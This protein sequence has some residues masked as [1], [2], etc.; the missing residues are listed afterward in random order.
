MS[1]TNKTDNYH[2]SQFVGTD[3]PSILNDYNGDMRKIDTAIKEVATA[4]GDNATNIAELQVSVRQHGTEIGGLNS[5]V[6][7]LSG[8]VIEIESKIPLDASTENQLVT[9]EQVLPKINKLETSVEDILDS[10]VVLRFDL[11]VSEQN[12][13]YGQVLNDIKNAVAQYR[14]SH[15]EY[16]DYYVDKFVINNSTP[17][18]ATTPYSLTFSDFDLISFSGYRVGESFSGIY[19]FEFSADKVLLFSVDS[20]TYAEKADVTNA[21][22][23]AFNANRFFVSLSKANIVNAN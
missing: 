4:E 13:T 1:S 11:T 12:K 22:C 8:R 21:I 23:Y 3:I 10:N 18:F 15:Q 6:N 7:S 17:F 16:D 14:A 9:T 20:S 2:L 19:D 5:T